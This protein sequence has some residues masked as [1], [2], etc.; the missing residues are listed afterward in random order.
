MKNSEK[1]KN[2]EKFHYSFPEKPH[3]QRVVK[4]DSRKIFFR[5]SGEKSPSPVG[6]IAGLLGEEHILIPKFG[7]RVDKG[8]DMVFEGLGQGIF[9]G[10]GKKKRKGKGK[11]KESQ[12]SKINMNGYL[13]KSYG[14]N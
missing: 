1:L 4:I 13:L 11:G 7:Q 9:M 2:S 14:F 5:I 8:G 12:V 10:G 6:K 3:N